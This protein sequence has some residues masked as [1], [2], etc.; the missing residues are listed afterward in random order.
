MFRRL[1]S[2][3]R[4]RSTQPQQDQVTRAAVAP[5]LEQLE[6]RQLMAVSPVTAGTK[7][8]GVNLSENNISS[9][10]TLITIPFSNNINLVDASKL[11]LFGYA[12]NPLSSNLAQVKKT[13]NITKAEVLTL[14]A[15]GDGD[16][17][18]SLLQITTD[19]L[20]RKGGTII[21][22]EG[23]L[24]DDNG[25]TVATQQ[26]KTLKGQNKERFTLAN[27]LFTVTDQTRFTNDLYAGANPASASTTVPEATATA[28][29]TAFL[30]KKV[31]AGILTQ[32][33]ADAAIARYNSA[34]AKGTVPDHNLRAALF[35]LTGTFAESAIGA[36][37]DGQNITG[38]PY[39]IIDFQTPDDTS[40]PVAQTSARPSDGRLRTIFK[41]EFKGEPFQAL[42]AWLAH[43]AL[44]QDSA[45]GLQEE[46][47]STIVETLVIAQ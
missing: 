44:H 8:K 42:S 10:S 43:E 9:N 33:K 38:K 24:N 5:V 13:V 4:R 3:L 30:N 20:M 36:Y 15:D 23:A 16:Q 29:L 37:L 47:F 27:R 25:D 39:T 28:N 14:D 31:T 45:I 26:R 40:V 11:R 6:R 19:R 17:D 34:A 12:L 22:N 2:S 46:E 21:I 41:P 35:S 1:A 18:H 7:I 32:A